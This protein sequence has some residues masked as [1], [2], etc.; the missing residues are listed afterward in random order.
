[1]IGYNRDNSDKYGDL[2]LTSAV[3]KWE[4]FYTPRI[5]EVLQDKFVSRN[6]WEGVESEI[7]DISKFSKSV[8]KGTEKVVDEERKKLVEGKYDVFYGPIYDNDGNLRVGEGESMTDE[9][10]LNLFEWY[11]EGVVIDEK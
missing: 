7:V 3:W 2:Y 11:V 4:N 5:K 9:A 6:Y 10:M 8:K 1:M